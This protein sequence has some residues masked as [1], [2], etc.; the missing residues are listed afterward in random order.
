MIYLDY[1][2]TTPVNPDVLNAYNEFNLKY[3]GNPN[4]THELGLLASHQVNKATKEIQEILKAETYE[5]IYTSGATEG[6]NLAIIGYA[7][8]NKHKGK[9]IIST[10]YEHSSVTAC[11]NYLSKQGFEIDI[12]DI[13]GNGLINPKELSDLIRSDTILVSISKVNSELGIKQDF[14][15]I[16]EVLK[17]YP[18]VVFHSDMTQAIGKLKVDLEGIDLVTFS[19][20]KFYGLKGIG[21][22]LRKKYLNLTP[23]IHGGKSTSIFRGGTPPAPLINSLAVALR[24]AYQDFEKKIN[25]IQGLYDFLKGELKQDIKHCEINFSNGIPQILNASFLD[26]EAHKLHKELSK[27]QIY[28]STQTACNSDSSFS[29]LVRNLTGSDKRAETSI[30]ISLSHLTKKVELVQ[31][32]DSIK[33]IINENS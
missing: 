17:A 12:L 22:L 7:L 29:Q 20:H 32:I 5:V 18:H 31:L 4:S 33:E 10:P 28:V 15:K 9:H 23:V 25:H 21:A 16:K 27:R 14:T 13:S 30:R 1:S 24:L 26:I 2:A 19:A 6:N 3:F 11:L 8:A